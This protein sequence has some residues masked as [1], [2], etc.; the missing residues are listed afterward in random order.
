MLFGSGQLGVEVAG[1]GLYDGEVG[2]SNQES[3]VYMQNGSTVIT[4]AQ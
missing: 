4:G 2:F 3:Q 1:L